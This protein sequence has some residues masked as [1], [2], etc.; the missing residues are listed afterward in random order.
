[1]RKLVVILSALVLVAPLGQA[2]ASAAPA[3]SLLDAPSG[4]EDVVIFAGGGTQLSSGFFFPGTQVSDGEGG[5]TGAP[6]TTVPKGSNIRFVNLDHFIVAGGAHKITSFAT[7]KVGKKGKKR[8]VP[9][10][11]S[12]TVDGPGETTVKTSHVKPGTYLYYCPIH[13]GMLGAIE[14]E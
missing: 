2:L 4:A 13:S 7:V 5:T 3:E 11:S 12:K 1:M 8:K 10:F 14:V 9:L 6:P